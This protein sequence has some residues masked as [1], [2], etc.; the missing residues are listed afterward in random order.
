MTICCIRSKKYTKVTFMVHNYTY[1][2][3]ISKFLKKIGKIKYIKNIIFPHYGTSILLLL[4]EQ[5]CN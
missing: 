4:K 1:L 2:K 5:F 3:F